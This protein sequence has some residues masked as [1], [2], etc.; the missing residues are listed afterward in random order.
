[1]MFVQK[2]SIHRIFKRLAKALISL[3]VCAGWSEPLLV[4]HTT[5]LE[6]SCHGSNNY[7]FHK[8]AFHLLYTYEF[9]HLIW[10]NKLWMIHCILWGVTDYIFQLKLKVFLWRSLT[11]NTLFAKVPVYVFSIHMVN[12]CELRVYI[13]RT[14]LLIRCA[15]D[16]KSVGCRSDNILWS[17]GM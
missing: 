8:H 5:L 6:I 14:L 16:L 3:R 13:Y 15:S 17:E 12:S 9:F 11:V 7:H 2:L 1:M 4:A 10:N